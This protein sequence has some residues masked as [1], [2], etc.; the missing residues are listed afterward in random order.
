MAI[1]AI[2]QPG[3]R[4]AGAIL[5]E[6]EGFDIAIAAPVEIARCRVMLRV[7]APPEAVR[8]HGHDADEPPERVI[9]ARGRQERAMSAV[10]LDDEE[11]H[12]EARSRDGEQDRQPVGVLHGHPHGGQQGHERDGGR[13]DLNDG[14]ARVGAP[15]FG[16]VRGELSRFGFEGGD[17]VRGIRACRWWLLCKSVCRGHSDGRLRARLKFCVYAP[18][19]FHPPE[20]FPHG[21]EARFGL[22]CPGTWERGAV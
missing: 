17:V 5:G 12:Q 14:A 11:A 2:A 21:V 1:D 18:E 6:R 4:R 20:A 7:H 16:A 22:S 15:V 19:P 3:P 13:D 9:G 8:G 10:V